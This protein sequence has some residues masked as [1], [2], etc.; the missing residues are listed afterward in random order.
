MELVP[1]PICDRIRGQISLELDGELSQLERAMVAS[2]VRRCAACADFRATATSF[3]HALRAAPLEP[4]ARPMEIPSLRRRALAEV[5][6]GAVRVAAAAAGIAVVLTLGFSNSGFFGSQG[7]RTGPSA[8]PAYLQSMDYERRLMEQ[9]IDR[10][11]GTNMNIA[12]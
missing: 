4:L 12:V 6:V 8:H 9:Q 10:S 5:R 11:R 2:H 1:H 7:L 3:T